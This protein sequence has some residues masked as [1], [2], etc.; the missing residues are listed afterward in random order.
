[1]PSTLDPGE[2]GSTWLL[3]DDAGGPD[4]RPGVVVTCSA[5]VLALWAFFAP[6]PAD[7]SPV[8]FAVRIADGRVE[9]HGPVT[10]GGP[11]AGFHDEVVPLRGDIRRMLGAAAAT[12]SLISNGYY[13][14]WNRA[15]PRENEVVRLF[16]RACR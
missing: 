15:S 9:R 8:R 16:A 11:G 6:Y 13:S 10:R 3:A 7:G 4:W 2:L 1:M 5:G 12:G 14:F